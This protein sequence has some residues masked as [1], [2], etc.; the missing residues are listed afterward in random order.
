MIKTHASLFSG[1]GAAE[2]AADWMGWQSLFHCEI[3][4]FPRR[5][6]EYWYPNAVSYEDITKTDF[7]PWRGKIDILTGGFPCQSFS[8][9]GKRLGDR[10]DRYLWPEDV[11]ERV[12]T[13]DDAL[14]EL[15]DDNQ[16]VKEYYE[17]W[18]LV[19]DKDVSKDYVAYLKL[20]IVCAALNEGWEPQFTKDE[21]RWFPWFWLYTQDEINNM[22]EQ[23]KQARHLRSTA[24]YETE[25]A[26]FAFAYSNNAPS[27]TD[28]YFGSR[29]CLKSDALAKYCGRQFTD[30]W[31]D[32]LL[33]RK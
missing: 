10:D 14:K 29:L 18:Q 19:G 4:E 23:E 5:V 13:F 26:G 31:E 24:Y 17:R 9:A 22:D 27:N 32:F 2:I 30:I 20:R 1:I 15:G 16:L 6:L 12:K 25:Y 7:T 21:V 28:T 33:I 8:M 3:Q 11:M